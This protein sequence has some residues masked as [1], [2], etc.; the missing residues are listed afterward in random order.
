MWGVDGSKRDVTLVYPFVLPLAPDTGQMGTPSSQLCRLLGA[1]S[2]L[3]AI[4]PHSCGTYVRLNP[5]GPNPGFVVALKHLSL[6][7][8]PHGRSIALIIATANVP[9]LVRKGYSPVIL[10]KTEDGPQ[11]YIFCVLQDE[12]EMFV[13]DYRLE[14]RTVLFVEHFWVCKNFQKLV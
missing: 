14:I 8:P 5:S 7:P 6:S 11:R 4:G 1:P 9:I 2:P 13:N 10:E 3:L 12:V